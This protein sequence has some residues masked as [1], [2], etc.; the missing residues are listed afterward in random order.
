M[1]GCGVERQLRTKTACCSGPEFVSRFPCG[2]SQP[3]GT[4]G[5]LMS[6][7]GL[8]GTRHTHVAQTEMEAKH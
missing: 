3:P 5:D 8:P 2:G 4:P 6:F 1:P 7:S